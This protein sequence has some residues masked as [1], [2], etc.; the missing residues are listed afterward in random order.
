MSP[1]L[2]QNDA[3]LLGLAGTMLVAA[4]G[5]AGGYYVISTRS[6]ARAATPPK[7]EVAAKPTPSAPGKS[8]PALDALLKRTVDI[9]TGSGIAKLTWADLGVEVDP[10]E[11]GRAGSIDNDAALSA[12]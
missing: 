10:D 9:K 11:L 6:E 1:R 4:G 5:L 12:P 7:T 2:G 8:S 3:I